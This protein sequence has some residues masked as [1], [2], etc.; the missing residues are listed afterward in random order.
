[1]SNFGMAHE[2]AVPQPRD[3]SVEANLECE[4]AMMGEVVDRFGEDVET[5]KVSE[6]AFHAKV[7]AADSPA[8]YGWVFPFEGKIQIAAP[9]EIREKYRSMVKAANRTFR[10]KRERATPPDEAPV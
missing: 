7:H 1:M 8:F 2:K 4:N 6:D 9:E 5:W 3:V 10:K